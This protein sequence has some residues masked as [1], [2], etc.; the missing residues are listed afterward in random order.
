MK[1]VQK[2]SEKELQQIA[3]AGA[4]WWELV[5]QYGPTIAEQI[6]KLMGGGSKDS[7]SSSSGGTQ[8]TTTTPAGPT[9]NNC[10]NSGT[11]TNNSQDSRG[12]NNN[13]G[14]FSGNQTT[15]FGK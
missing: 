15:T 1:N 5:K 4:S 12:S 3:A 11:S 10:G 9:F 8:T 6:W 14:N 2:L 13:V 7:G